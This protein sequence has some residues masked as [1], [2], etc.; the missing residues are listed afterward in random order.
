MKQHEMAPTES[1]NVEAVSSSDLPTTWQRLLD[2]LAARGPG[3]PSILSHGELKSLADGKAVIE[4][5]SPT[6]AAMIDRNGKK[7]VIRDELS[8]ML[9]TP[10]SLAIEVS[11]QAE[12]APGPQP[13]PAKRPTPPSP[14]KAAIP[15]APISTGL[16]ITPEL[17]QELR[18]KNPLIAAV[19]TELGG[20]I[21]KVE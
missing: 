20:E 11:E 15:S 1:P 13:T 4:F 16:R 7:D 9:D 14:A 10:V 21:V 19:M 6:F 5:S 18:E 12:A 8:K 3:I 2:I 17:K